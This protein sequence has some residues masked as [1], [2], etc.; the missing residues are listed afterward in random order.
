VSGSRF[1]ANAEQEN[2]YMDNDMLSFSAARRRMLKLF[3]F[4]VTGT[5]A[6]VIV[7]T[8]RIFAKQFLDE[9]PTI[10]LPDMVYDP[11]LQMMVDPATRRPIYEDAARITVASGLPTITSGCGNCPKKDDTGS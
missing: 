5:A 6:G 2:T 1:N 11:D 8:D 7:A 3:G 10:K 9:G 4:G